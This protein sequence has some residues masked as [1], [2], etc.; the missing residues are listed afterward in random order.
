MPGPVASLGNCTLPPSTPELL[1]SGAI[2]PRCEPQEVVVPFVGGREAWAPVILE[3]GLAPRG[4]VPVLA[5]R[6]KNSQ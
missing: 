6:I 5:E 1:E 4:A 2:L 3:K